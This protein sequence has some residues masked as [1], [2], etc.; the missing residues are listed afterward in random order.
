MVVPKPPQKR[1][2]ETIL[3]ALCMQLGWSDEEEGGFVLGDGR[4]FVMWFASPAK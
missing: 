3:R 2:L 4:G 1:T